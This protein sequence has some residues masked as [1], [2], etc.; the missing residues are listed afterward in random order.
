MTTENK[1]TAHS[2]YTLVAWCV[3]TGDKHR[4]QTQE[5]ENEGRKTGNNA[6]NPTKSMRKGMRHRW[7]Q[8][9]QGR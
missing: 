5:T 3:S 9:G 2:D 8:S 6:E 4:R 7:I 1:V